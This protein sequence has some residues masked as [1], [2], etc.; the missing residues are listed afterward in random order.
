M[1]PDATNRTNVIEFTLGHDVNDTDGDLD[2]DETRKAMG[3]PMHAR[4]AVAI[5]GGTEEAPIG[6][7]YTTTNDGMLHAFDMTDGRASS[8]PSSPTKCCSV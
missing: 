5:Y 4:P 6:T 8:G 3:D 7:V 2:I 1:V